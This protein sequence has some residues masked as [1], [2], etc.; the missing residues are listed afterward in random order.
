M[1]MLKG[2]RPDVGSAL[3][4]PIRSQKAYHFGST[5]AWS[6]LLGNSESDMTMEAR[7]EQSNTNTIPGERLV[8]A[9]RRARWTHRAGRT[10]GASGGSAAVL[11]AFEF[12]TD[13]EVDAAG[14]LG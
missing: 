8:G 11:D 14:P 6:K 9:T 7:R 3:K 10:P 5:C 1:T 13:E 12:L 2:G 4:A